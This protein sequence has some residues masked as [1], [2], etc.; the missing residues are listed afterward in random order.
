MLSFKQYLLETLETYPGNYVSIKTENVANT[1]SR[2]GF[3]EPNSGT[4]PPN[5]D[6]HCTI[7]YSTDSKVCP[8]YIIKSINSSKFPRSYVANISGIDCFDSLPEDGV[9]SEAKSCIVLKIECPG[10]IILHDFMKSF[11]LQ[12]SYA[13]FSPHITL[14]YNMDV[15]EAHLYKNA[16]NVRMKNKPHQILLDNIYSETINTD[17]V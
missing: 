10:I 1:F 15:D 3:D 13:E 8:K 9:R 5:G 4:A 2:L 6:Y 11:G 17:Y 16:M 12:H 7:M 14:R